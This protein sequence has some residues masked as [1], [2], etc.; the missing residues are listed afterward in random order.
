MSP[1][2]RARNVFAYPLNKS[3]VKL[4]LS[5]EA[6]TGPTH[7]SLSVVALARCYKLFLTPAEAAFTLQARRQKS[8]KGR[9][10][11]FTLEPAATHGS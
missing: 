6:Y 3:N 5:A 8:K 9:G 1:N 4:P 7:A 11:C 2:P 10:K